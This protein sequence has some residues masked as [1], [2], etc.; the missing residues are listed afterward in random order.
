MPTHPQALLKCRQTG[1]E[2]QVPWLLPGHAGCRQAKSQ[3]HIARG[4]VLSLEALPDHAAWIP[5]Y[6]SLR[7]GIN[8]ETQTQ[9]SQVPGEQLPDNTDRYQRAANGLSL[10]W[11]PLLSQKFPRYSDPV[12]SPCKSAH[13]EHEKTSSQSYYSEVMIHPCINCS[14]EREGDA[15]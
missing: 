6:H 1:L 12:G 3:M 14:A 8:K 2:V 5:Q 4:H 7:L 10:F 15:R 9:V 11:G 13:H